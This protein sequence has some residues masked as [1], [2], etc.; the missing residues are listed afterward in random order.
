MDQ[1]A[2]K[3]LAQLLCH[4]GVVQKMVRQKLAFEVE[5]KKWHESTRRASGININKT[6]CGKIAYESNENHRKS[7]KPQKFAK[8][9]DSFA[10]LKKI[11]W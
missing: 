8:M 2:G 9:A 10:I 4:G 1:D 3:R 11:F 7:Q 6:T 5:N